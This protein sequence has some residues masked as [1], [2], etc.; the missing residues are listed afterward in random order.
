MTACELRTIE[1]VIEWA[2]APATPLP[3]VRETDAVA[4]FALSLEAGPPSHRRA[5][6]PLLAGLDLLRSRRGPDARYAVLSWLERGRLAPL[7]D[8]LAGLAQ[9]AYYGDPDVLQMLG[10]DPPGDRS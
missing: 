4:A 8:L 7:A 3:P 1:A 2:V 6:W 9:L 10:Y 5:L